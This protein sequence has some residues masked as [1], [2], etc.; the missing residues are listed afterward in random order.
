[1]T[2]ASKPT[3]AAPNVPTPSGVKVER[4]PSGHVNAPNPA[5]GEVP[6]GEYTNR[7]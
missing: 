7:K 3:P 1:M 5:G 6:R 2:S 4:Q